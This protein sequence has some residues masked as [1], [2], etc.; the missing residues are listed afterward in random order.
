LSAQFESAFL[1]PIE[2]YEFEIVGHILS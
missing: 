2:E 1:V